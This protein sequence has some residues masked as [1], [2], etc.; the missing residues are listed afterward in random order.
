MRSGRHLE[1]DI[2]VT[3]TG[4]KLQMLG[5]AAASVD[6]RS[7]GDIGERMTYKA[8]LVE[9]IPNMAVM[10]GYTN[11][12]WTLKIDLACHYLL[13][14]LDHM[15]RHRYQRWSLKHRLARYDSAK[16]IP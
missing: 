16:Q 12:S 13:R 4:L 7:S 6:R 3:A 10:F 2:I 1:A 8:V 11:A 9:G 15:D 5:G 14:L